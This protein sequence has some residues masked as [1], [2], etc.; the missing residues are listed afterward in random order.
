MKTV[1]VGAMPRELA[2][3]EL[4]GT[5]LVP[6]EPDYTEG[7]LAGMRAFEQFVQTSRL[8]KEIRKRQRL[9]VAVTQKGDKLV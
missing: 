5:S 7:E 1:S 2:T 3:R 9:G 8:N 4:Y 6:P